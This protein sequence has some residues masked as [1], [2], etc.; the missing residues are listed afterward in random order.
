MLPTL[1]CNSMFNS[2]VTLGLLTSIVFRREELFSLVEF[3]SSN[4][5][6]VEEISLNMRFCID[7][8]ILIYNYTLN[9]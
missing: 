9:L 6:N 5:R 8:Q 2:D 4:H 7:M 1:Q 3:K